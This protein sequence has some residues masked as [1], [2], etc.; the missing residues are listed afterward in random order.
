[1]LRLALRFADRFGEIPRMKALRTA[2][3][4]AVMTAA[5]LLSLV[6][7]Q[8]RGTAPSQGSAQGGGSASHSILRIVSPDSWQ[9]IRRNFVTVKYELISA[10][11]SGSPSFRLQL[12]TRDPVI[13][14]LSEYT[15]TGLALGRH[16]ITVDQ[17]DA[18][19]TTMPGT[20]SEINFYVSSPQ[21]GAPPG[22]SLASVEGSPA[23]QRASFSP[24]DDALPSAASS[25]PLLSVI[26]FG[27]LVGGIASALNTR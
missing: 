1:M 5:P 16:T 4:L 18:N 19:N 3:I 9:T 24:D 22:T 27:A 17:L 20:H 2:V 11:A 21:R 8:N 14:A 26:G 13:T 12:D 7:A 10:L 15:F 25:L 23:L 6:V